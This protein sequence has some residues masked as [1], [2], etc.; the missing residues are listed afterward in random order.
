MF[1][2]GLSDWAAGTVA[3][4][5]DNADPDAVVEADRGQ[6]GQLL[7]NLCINAQD[8]LRGRPGSVAVSIRHTA[9]EPEVAALLPAPAD[10]T[11]ATAADGTVR[12]AAGR[13][14]P[15][16]AYVSLIVSDDGPGMEAEL[17]AQAFTPFFTTKARGQGTGLGLAVVKGHRRRP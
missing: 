7:L 16:A 11:V 15:A 10:I 9:L 6:L 17:L 8:A 3:F 4:R 5:C 1:A 2:R 13:Y 12:A 14:D